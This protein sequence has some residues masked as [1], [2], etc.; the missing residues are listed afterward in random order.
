MT[1]RGDLKH[2][3]LR[4]QREQRIVS[5]GTLK[6]RVVAVI[7]DGLDVLLQCQ[8]VAHHLLHAERVCCA[9]VSRIRNEQALQQMSQ[10]LENKSIP[11]HQNACSQRPEDKLLLSLLRRKCGRRPIIASAEL[12]VEINDIGIRFTDIA[13]NAI[14]T[15]HAGEEMK[16]TSTGPLLT[17]RSARSRWCIA[18]HLISIRRLY[19]TISASCAYVMCSAWNRLQIL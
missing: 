13:F 6:L 19:R 9:D 14:D 10:P 2:A 12:H 5:L 17:C 15:L 11:R 8:H 1:R 3:Y 16:N 18:R 4:R 7:G